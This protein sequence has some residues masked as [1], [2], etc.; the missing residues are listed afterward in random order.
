MGRRQF[1]DYDE[2]EWREEHDREERHRQRREKQRP[3]QEP[4]DD[5]ETPP[6][7]RSRD[8]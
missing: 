7:G 1:D 8:R 6:P 3:R 4:H 2:D 5:G